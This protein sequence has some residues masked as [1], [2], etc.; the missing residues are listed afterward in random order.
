MA[1]RL[2]EQLM[3]DGRAKGILRRLVSFNRDIDVSDVKQTL[4]RG[5]FD[6][7]YK[8]DGIMKVRGHLFLYDLKTTLFARDEWPRISFTVTSKS[9]VKWTSKPQPDFYIFIIDTPKE[10]DHAYCVTPQCLST[11]ID[12]ARG[13][14]GYV[15]LYPRA[16]RNASSMIIEDHRIDFNPDHP[17]EELVKSS[18]ENLNGVKTDP[19]FGGLEKI[20]DGLA[21]L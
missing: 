2:N 5:V 13:G 4:F 7:R 14:P 9:G 18:E 1:W 10:C 16:L 15:W 20:F 21:F 17:F 3:C 11:I 8:V 12:G 19:N 6:T